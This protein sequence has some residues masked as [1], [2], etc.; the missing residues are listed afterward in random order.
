MAF[1]QKELW[2]SASERISWH[3]NLDTEEAIQN[4]VHELVFCFIL[5][6]NFKLSLLNL[7]HLK[8]DSLNMLMVY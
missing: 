4:R 7:L 5:Y 6:L 2:G 3:E 1:E 8:A